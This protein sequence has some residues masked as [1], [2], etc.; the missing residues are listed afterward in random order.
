MENSTAINQHLTPSTIEAIEL[1]ERTERECRQAFDSSEYVELKNGKLLNKEEQIAFFKNVLERISIE[2]IFRHQHREL[3][4]ALLRGDLYRCWFVVRMSMN[5][6]TYY[7][8]IG[9]INELCVMEFP[10]Q[11]HY[12]ETGY[13]LN[14][15]HYGCEF[16]ISINYYKT[17]QVES[18]HSYTSESSNKDDGLNKGDGLNGECVWYDENGIVNTIILYKDGEV[19]EKYTRPYESYADVPKSLTLGKFKINKPD[20]DGV[21]DIELENQDFDYDSTKITYNQLVELHQYIGG[22]ISNINK[23]KT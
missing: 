22:I 16:D 23:N 20:E 2:H 5:Q 21:D 4:S 3:K 12:H 11:I 9:D 17:G 10:V 7:R 18:K 1:I 6:F 13:V 14:A 19:V 15:C 8:I